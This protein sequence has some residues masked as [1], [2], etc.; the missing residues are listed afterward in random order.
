MKAQSMYTPGQY[1]GK[2]DWLA[3]LCF[4]VHRCETEAAAIEIAGR[5]CG[6]PYCKKSHWVE[7]SLT[8]KGESFSELRKRAH[9]EWEPE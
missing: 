5:D 7:E 4:R 9:Q 2:G 1:S 6:A 8:S 3:L